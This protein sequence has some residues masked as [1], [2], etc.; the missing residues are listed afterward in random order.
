MLNVRPEFLLGPWVVYWEHIT[1]SKY[2]VLAWKESP[3]S[4]KGGDVEPEFFPFWPSL[5]MSLDSV[6]N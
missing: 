2:S 5:W 4:K 6:N 3:E 1:I